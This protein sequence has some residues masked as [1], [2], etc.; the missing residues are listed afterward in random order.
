M[1]SLK[2]RREIEL[3][4]I[5]SEIIKEAFQTLESMLRPG[6]TTQ[7]LD[8]KAEEIIRRAGAKPAF[9]GYRG[10]PATICAS[11]NDEVVHG[12]PS[13]RCLKEGDIISIDIGVL[14][15]GYYSDAART[16]P[17][18]MISQEAA[19]LITITRDSFY[20]GIEA[21]V[22]GARLG[23]LSYAIQEYVEN[24]G[25]SIVKDFVGHGIGNQLH[26]EPQIPNFGT[27]GTG[28]KLENGM[29]LA[30]E[31]M[32]NAGS[33]EIEILENGW[34]VVTADQSLSA[35]YENT[36]ALVDDKVIILT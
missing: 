10:F 22:P 8:M 6:V 36:I 18:G 20:A 33:W 27:Q 28:P 11:I 16:F 19:E 35:H 25:C 34:T 32:V 31:P 5:A 9:K 1:I 17:V 21:I 7:Y 23:D 30:I 2:S 13:E 4:R 12:I 26:E 15:E 14:R 24:H 29:T 3:I